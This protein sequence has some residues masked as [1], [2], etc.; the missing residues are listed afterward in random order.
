MTKL[1]KIAM[2]KKLRELHEKMRPH[3]NDLE[4]ECPANIKLIL[5][6]HKWINPWHAINDIEKMIY[7]VKK[8][9]CGD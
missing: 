8:I 2:L 1:E 4:H 6:V 3:V 7:S 5:Y 9:K